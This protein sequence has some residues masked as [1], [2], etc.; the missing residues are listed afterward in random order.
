[1]SANVVIQWLIVACLLAWSLWR[2]LTLFTPNRPNGSSSNA[3][4]GS[5]CNTC[6]ACTP[7]ESAEQPVQWRK[8]S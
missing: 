8:P 3:G 2:V 6:G 4:C 5:G 1:M 7:T